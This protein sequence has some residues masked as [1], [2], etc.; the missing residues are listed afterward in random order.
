MGMNEDAIYK[1]DN[2]PDAWSSIGLQAAMILNKLRCQ[3]QLNFD[4]QKNDEHGY[5]R[6]STENQRDR[7]ANQ[8]KIQQPALYRA[9]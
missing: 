8:E 2:E 9:K 3:A 6:G 5:A 4:E 7:T 1:Q